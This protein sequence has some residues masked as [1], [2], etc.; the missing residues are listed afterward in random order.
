MR[1]SGKTTVIVGGG[2]GM[3]AET[4]RVFASEGAQVIVADLNLNNAKTIAEEIN[5]DD[6][7]QTSAHALPVDVCDPKSVEALITAC[8]DFCPVDAL[9]NMVGYAKFNKTSDI[10]LDELMLTININL[11][12]VF[13]TC[14]AFGKDMVERKAGKIV[15]FASTA[16]ITGV[17][18]MAHYTAAKH[19]VVGL[20]KAL[21]CE[22]GQY[23]INVNCI[24]PGA[25][26]T[27]L[28]LSCTDE[29]WREERKARIPLA[30][31]ATP[32]DQARVALMLAS[33]DSDYLTGCVLTTDGGIAALAAGTSDNALRI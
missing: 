15:N 2:S 11:T 9:I 31:L 33:S 25:T 14:Q 6:Q 21:A 8:R 23:N 20:T 30:R 17:P 18:G 13:L 1:L 12:G 28:M 10:E 29:T 19:G 7:T 3:G 24:C 26:T 27:P 22:W 16:G 5:S 4:A 32:E